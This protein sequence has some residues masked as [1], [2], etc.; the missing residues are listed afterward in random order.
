MGQR[1]RHPMS[2]EQWEKACALTKSV[3]SNGRFKLIHFNFLHRTY[4]P[5]DL[6]KNRSLKNSKLPQVSK[7]FGYFYSLSLAM[8]E[9]AHILARGASENSSKNKCSLPCRNQRCGYW[10]EYKEKRGKNAIKVCPVAV[11]VGQKKGSYYLDGNK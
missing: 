8:P 3:S 5:D 6:A 7:P 10:E 9:R 1:S 11:G 2:E 4:H